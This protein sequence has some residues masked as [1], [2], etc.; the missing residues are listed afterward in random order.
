MTI[1]ALI[2]WWAK[3]I[4]KLLLSRI[5]ASYQIWQRFGLFKHGGMERPVYAYDVFT[6]HYSRF[7][8]DHSKQSCVVLELG[9]GDSLASTLVGAGKCCGALAVKQAAT[10][11]YLGC[12][13]NG[14]SE[15]SL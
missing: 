12:G 10:G 1:K 11:K 4:A 5:P 9:P 2:P 14:G 7:D 8:P 6:S 15:F 13:T 3:I